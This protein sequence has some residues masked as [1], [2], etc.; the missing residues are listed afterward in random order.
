MK[1]YEERLMASK[2]KARAE[3]LSQ[4]QETGVQAEPRQQLRHFALKHQGTKDQ[5]YMLRGDTVWTVGDRVQITKAGS[6][7]GKTA[8]VITPNWEG[9]IMVR[10]DGGGFVKKSYMANEL[11]II[12]DPSLSPRTKKS[13]ALAVVGEQAADEEEVE[14]M[15]FALKHQAT[16]D[17]AYK[18]RG[19]KVWMVD[20]KVEI[21]KE[22]SHTGKRAVVM[23][24]DWEGRIMVRMD[25]SDFITKSY[26]A[27]ELK[28]I[29]RGLAVSPQMKEKSL[30]EANDTPDKKK[31][32]TRRSSAIHFS[33]LPQGAE[34][35]GNV[36]DVN[37]TQFV[38]NPGASGDEEVSEPQVT[39][40]PGP[41]A[42]REKE[43][44]KTVILQAKDL[45]SLAKQSQESVSR[46]EPLERSAMSTALTKVSELVMQCDRI[47]VNIEGNDHPEAVP[48]GV[49]C[50][51]IKNAL[52]DV[53]AR[54]QE[55]DKASRK[56]QAVASADLG[57]SEA[58]RTKPSTEGA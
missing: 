4:S 12:G 40:A 45:T 5:A 1:A 20:D 10:M 36:N 7:T 37:D 31:T 46:K 15:H 48:F 42:A 52:W 50:T 34:E 2:V 3:G 28:L 18:L 23:I 24:P 27:N 39:D 33:H 6:H 53:T 16:K 54:L 41:W 32:L 29:E 8:V 56:L 25:G 26:M 17:Q 43:Q 21:T 58:E 9:R 13:F 51:D 44:L 57:Y 11:K 14:E 55:A 19:D 49:K 22:G 38:A 30:G 35:T 47:L